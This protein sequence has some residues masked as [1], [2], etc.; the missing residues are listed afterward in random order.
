MA[1]KYIGK[2]IRHE[3]LVVTGST[4]T[5]DLGLSSGSTAIYTNNITNGYPT[6]NPWGQNLE[7]SY[8]NNFDNTTHVSE[9][10]RF[11]SGVLSHS[12]DVAD[13]A[14][15]KKTY[16]SIDTNENT[17]GSTDSINGYVPQNFSSIGSEEL[18]YLNGKGFADVGSTLFS[19]I[20]SYGSNGRTHYVDFDSNSGGSKG[21][22]SLAKAL[23]CVR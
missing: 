12:L 13:V 15:N 11:M 7:G 8:F 22:L 14:P 6:S 18:S 5:V 20:T 23:V 1:F 17:L 2:E 9:V 21:R 16:A 4:V 3:P 10:L 19:G